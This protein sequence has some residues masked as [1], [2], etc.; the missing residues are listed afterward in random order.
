[1]TFSPDGTVYEISLSFGNPVQPASRAILVSRSIDG[2]LN[3]SDPVALT[4]DQDVNVVL[5]KESMTA[6]PTDARLVY[7]VWD[8]LTEVANPNPALITGA[9]WFTRMVDGV[10]EPA[11]I[12]Y[13]P[14]A[15]ARTIANQIAVLSNGDLIN[16]L[17]RITR[18]SS[19]QPLREVA[20]QRSADKGLTWSAPIIIDRSRTAGVMDPKGNR[21]VRSGALIP[22]VAADSSGK[23]YAVWQDAR[24]SGGSRDGIV[25]STS[26]DGGLTW[27]G[28]IQVNQARDTPA[29]TPAIAISSSGTVGVTYYD[30]REDNPNDQNLLLTSYWLATSTDGGATWTE[31]EVGAPVDLRTAPLVE[32][33]FVG[34]YE[35]LAHDG[36]SF[37]PLFSAASFP[38][39]HNTTGIFVRLTRQ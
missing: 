28:P 34:D 37:I 32:G 1:V 2:G 15:D 3:W 27:S 36:Q 14:G 13:A 23:L 7:A 22:S 38:N 39:V 24:F 25:L 31:T 9:T 29:F 4:R 16:L 6:D 17:L 26:V 18:S 20:I 30:F 5:D 11:R 21:R 10:W 8:R 19:A 33:Y 35:G 12:I